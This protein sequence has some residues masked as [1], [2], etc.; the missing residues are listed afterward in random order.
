MDNFPTRD[1]GDSNKIW[2]EL[3]KILRSKM[4]D[5][6]LQI[7]GPMSTT[8]PLANM[9][10]FLQKSSVVPARTQKKFTAT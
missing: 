8:S 5:R 7:K 1:Y 4:F 3:V 2:T 9:S 10:R 6:V